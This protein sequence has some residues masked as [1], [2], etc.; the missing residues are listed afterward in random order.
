MKNSKSERRAEWSTTKIL[1]KA[2]QGSS[3]ALHHSCIMTPPPGRGCF[4]STWAKWKLLSQGREPRQGW[5]RRRGGPLLSLRTTP[6]GTGL[7]SHCSKGGFP[8]LPPFPRGVSWWRRVITEMNVPGEDPRGSETF[9]EAQ[10]IPAGCLWEQ[11]I[12]GIFSPAPTTLWPSRV[13]P[14]PSL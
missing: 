4:S 6:Y 2:L 3:M 7:I 12:P 1:L 10:S 9:L 8:S 13:H 11:G 14:D 5:G